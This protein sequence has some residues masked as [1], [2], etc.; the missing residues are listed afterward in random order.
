M[1]VC[2]GVCVCEFKKPVPISALDF[3]EFQEA[4]LLYCK[5]VELLVFFASRVCVNRIVDTHTILLLNLQM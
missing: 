5:M 4:E 2:M 1:H 3:S